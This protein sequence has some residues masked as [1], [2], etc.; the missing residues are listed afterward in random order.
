MRYD[1]RHKLYDSRWARASKAF[2][3]ANPDCVYC[4]ANKTGLPNKSEVTD[5]IV[6][7]HGDI[8]LFWNPE[9]WQALCHRC[10]NSDKQAEERAGFSERVGPDGWPLDPQHPANQR[11]ENAENRRHQTA[12]DP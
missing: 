6:P 11:I 3:L 9:N 7:H 5:H 8:D 2:L 4:L 1:N 10:H 12:G